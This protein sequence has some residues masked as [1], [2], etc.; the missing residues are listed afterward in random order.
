MK[1]RGEAALFFLGVSSNVETLSLLS[2]KEE[3]DE[4]SRSRSEIINMPEDSDFSVYHMSV[5]V[6]SCRRQTCQYLH[7]WKRVEVGLL[8]TSISGEFITDGYRVS[9]ISVQQSI[10]LD[11][12]TRRRLRV[13]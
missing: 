9:I 10:S 5:S 2:S 12:G 4:Y 7:H 8:T 11:N 13:H 1:T 6:S 3:K